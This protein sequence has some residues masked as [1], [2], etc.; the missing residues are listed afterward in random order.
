MESVYAFE[1][2]GGKW[3]IGKSNDVPRRFQEHAKGTEGAAAW[4]RL[5]PAVRIDVVRPAHSPFDET[6]MT[7]EYMVKYGLDNVRGA[8]YCQ[9]TLHEEQRKF[10]QQRLAYRRNVCYRCGEPFHYAKECQGEKGS[11]EPPSILLMYSTYKAAMEE[12]QRLLTECETKANGRLTYDQ[13]RNLL[14]ELPALQESWR[15]AEER[16]NQFHC[17]IVLANLLLPLPPNWLKAAFWTR[18]RLLSQNSPVPPFTLNATE[19]STELNFT[20]YDCNGCGH[21]WDLTL[22]REYLY[23]L[24]MQFYPEREPY[25]VESI[26]STVRRQN[27]LGLESRASEFAMPPCC[28]TCLERMK[29][30]LSTS[31]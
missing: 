21:K 26:D 13:G 5:Y 29:F 12:A 20:P 11:K 19:K 6:N 16:W 25:K 24:R 7:E 28:G 9:V 14:Y 4:T 2:R 22:R 10:L 1:C 31:Y 8:E 27:P 30:L 15:K 18:F 17:N 3:Y 23:R